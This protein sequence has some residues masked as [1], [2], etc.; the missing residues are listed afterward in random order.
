MCPAQE[1]G[2]LGL[3]IGGAVQKNA[4]LQIE[5]PNVIPVDRQPAIRQRLG[6]HGLDPIENPPLRR[7]CVGVLRIDL[8]SGVALREGTLD[9][10]VALDGALRTQ[11]L[12]ASARAVP[13]N[14][15]L[16]VIEQKPP[17]HFQITRIGRMIADGLAQDADA[18]LVRLVVAL[19][20]R[21]R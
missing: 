14:W 5:Q 9:F 15:N 11:L 3:E 18:H 13:D 12:P 7:H 21:V 2:S 8:Q 10:I 16:V 1:T 17:Q 6:A 4:D 20:L 19:P